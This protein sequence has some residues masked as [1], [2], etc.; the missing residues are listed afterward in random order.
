MKLLIADSAIND[1]MDIKTYYRE[2]GF[3]QIGDQFVSEIIAHLEV[4]IEHPEIGRMVPEFAESD[5]RE[6][7]HPP[8]RVVYWLDNPQIHVVRVW[9]SERLLQLPDL[10]QS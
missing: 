4:L 3:E 7:I 9:R 5:I 6:L 2:Q 1:L 8:F 10:N